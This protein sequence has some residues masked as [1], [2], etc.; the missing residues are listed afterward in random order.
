MGT[1]SPLTNLRRPV[2]NSSSQRSLIHVLFK[3]NLHLSA[4]KKAEREKAHAPTGAVNGALQADAQVRSGK[5]PVLQVPQQKR[6]SN[7]IPT[8]EIPTT[9]VPA[10][11]TK[12]QTGGRAEQKQKAHKKAPKPPA[13]LTDPSDMRRVSVAI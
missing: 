10:D 8:T 7:G 6:P 2:S 3:D 12:Q 4:L 11:K 9:Q 1:P 13:E 5:M